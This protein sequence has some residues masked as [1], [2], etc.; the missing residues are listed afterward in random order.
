MIAT[1]RFRNDLRRQ[2]AKMVAKLKDVPLEYGEFD[3]MP[4]YL[5]V[6]VTY[7]V[8]RFQLGKLKII[9]K[10]IQDEEDAA[11]KEAE[12]EP[13]VDSADADPPTSL[14]LVPTPITTKSS[15]DPP[16]VGSTADGLSPRRHD[17]V[18]EDDEAHAAQVAANQS[19][20]G[21]VPSASAAI[22]SAAQHRRVK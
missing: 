1:W 21:S 13:E 6:P 4:M 22:A 17:E 11:L 20:D 5:T 12:K 15:I 8:R 19:A 16:E 10:E 2:Q 3:E 9:L 7:R 14:P 18:E